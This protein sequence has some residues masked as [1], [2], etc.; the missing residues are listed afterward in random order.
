MI[1][2]GRS[3]I[4]HPGLYLI[5]DVSMDN[6]YPKLPLIPTPPTNTQSPHQ[7][8]P[9]NSPKLGHPA[10]PALQQIHHAF[11]HGTKSDNHPRKMIRSPGDESPISVGDKRPSL[12]REGGGA[13]PSAG[14][15]GLMESSSGTTIDGNGQFPSFHLAVRNN[16]RDPDSRHN[17]THYSLK[18][19][20]A[21][22]LIIVNGRVMTSAQLRSL[23]NMIT[24][25]LPS[26][27]LD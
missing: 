17:W 5:F 9:L 23:Y 6:I 14:R 10:F 21:F 11:D 26:P 12:P 7:E 18:Y 2:A 22:S 24:V 13:P 19:M 3:G 4:C 8:L 1:F 27:G 25:Y 20:G 16:G 15:G